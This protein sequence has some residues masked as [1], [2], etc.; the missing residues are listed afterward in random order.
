MCCHQINVPFSS[1]WIL[2]H[3]ME[4]ARFPLHREY[5]FQLVPIKLRQAWMIEKESNGILL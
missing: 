3:K 4:W 5:L 2:I 1:H